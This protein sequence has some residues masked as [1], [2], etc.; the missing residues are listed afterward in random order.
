MHTGRPNLLTDGDGS[1]NTKRNIANGK[2]KFETNYKKKDRQTD[3]ANSRLTHVAC[4]LTVTATAT[5]THRF[6]CC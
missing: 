2:K 6:C 5:A 1:T 4:H 3:I